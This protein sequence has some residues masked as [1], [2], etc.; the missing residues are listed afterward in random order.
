LA[1]LGKINKNA[2]NKQKRF[3][4]V[5]FIYFSVL[6]ENDLGLCSKFSQSSKPDFTRYGPV[7]EASS[8]QSLS[9]S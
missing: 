3:I 1:S 4:R 2:S 8:G 9:F 5:I 6:K 7:A